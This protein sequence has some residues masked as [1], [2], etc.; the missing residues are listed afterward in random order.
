ME[1]SVN[2][3]AFQLKAGSF[4][5]EMAL[6]TGAPR[7]ADVTAVDYCNFLVLSLRD[8]R[9][10]MSRHPAVRSAVEAMAQERIAMNRAS[11]TAA[12]HTDEQVDHT[13]PATDK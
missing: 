11:A 12:D 1:V 13:A 6:L 4:F 3:K 8:F 9:L 10:F 2:G 5:G 7:T